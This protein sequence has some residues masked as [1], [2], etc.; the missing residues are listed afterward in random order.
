MNIIV[1]I[2]SV[3][4]VLNGKKKGWYLKLPCRPKKF[5]PGDYIF[6][7]VGKKI[8]AKAKCFTI[9]DTYIFWKFSEAEK[10]K[11][12]PGKPYLIRGYTHV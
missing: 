4:E 2:D 10:I 5:K 9:K 11:P 1:P 6:F 12:R 7:Q 8:V 3:N